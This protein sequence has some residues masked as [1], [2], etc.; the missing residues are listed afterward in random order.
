MVLQEVVK[1]PKLINFRGLDGQ[2]VIQLPD[3]AMITVKSN[4]GNV[5]PCPIT[6]KTK[7]NSKELMERGNKFNAQVDTDKWVITAIIKLNPVPERSSKEI[8]EEYEALM[9]DY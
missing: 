3:N 2:R 7:Y 1:I 5:Y 6:K 8:A 9:G 4:K